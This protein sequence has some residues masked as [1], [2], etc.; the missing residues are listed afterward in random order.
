M[1]EYRERIALPGVALVF[2]ACLSA[3]LA[4]CS[5]DETKGGNVPSS[6]EEASS[7][8]VRVSGTEGTSIAGNYGFLSGEL[9]TAE[10]TLGDQPLDYE[11]DTPQE[12]SVEPVDELDI[13]QESPPGVVASFRK[14]DPVAGELKAEILADGELVADGRTYAESGTVN[15]EWIPTPEPLPEDLPPE[16]T[17]PEEEP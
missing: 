2:A 9:Q 7:V 15:V 10:D 5:G 16:D 11:L 14:I 13:P 17:P 1:P 6:P 4:G 8:V 12:S 3:L